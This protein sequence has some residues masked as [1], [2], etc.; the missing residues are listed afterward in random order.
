MCPWAKYVDEAPAPRR[1]GDT[2]ILSVVEEV[3]VVERRLRLVEEVHVTEV[4]SEYRAPQT[5]SL[6]REEVNV[7]RL[8]PAG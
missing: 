4:R 7:E 5:V 1:D 8:A 6:R 2:T 3:L